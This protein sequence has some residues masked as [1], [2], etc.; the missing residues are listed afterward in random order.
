M[1]VSFAQIAEFTGAETLVAAPD[2][3]REIG[4]FCWDSREIEPG[5]FFIALAGEHHDGHDF[6]EAALETGAAG[7]LVSQMPSLELRASAHAHG[8]ALLHVADTQEALFALATA[9]RKTLGA[10]VI[11]VT[12]SSGKTGTKE[13]VAAVLRQYDP[14]LTASSGNHNNEVGLPATI[15]GANP[16]SKLLIL[17]MGMYDRGE[18][19][20]LCN[21]AAPR[22]GVVTN[23]GLAHLEVVGTRE[24]IARAKAELI[25]ALPNSSG[26][27]VLNGDD[28]WT[29]FIRE[30]SHTAERSVAVLQ[31]GM[32]AHNDIR[33]LNLTFREEDGRPIFDLKTLEADTVSVE[34]A[35]QGE[36]SVM[37]ALAAA[38]VG[39]HFGIPAP[40][41]ASA[42][43]SVQP[44]AMRQCN[45]LLKNGIRLIDDT[46]NANPDSMRAALEVLAHMPR[47][48][49]HVAVLG[50]MLELGEDEVA[51]H[52]EL[53]RVVAAT[54]VDEL[55]TI[56]ALARFIAEGAREAGL[57][58]R[59][60]R[61][62]DTIEE[63]NNAL[64]VT[65]TQTLEA[66]GAQ[67]DGHPIVLVKA[68]RSKGLERVVRHLTEVFGEQTG[69]PC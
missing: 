67:H 17:E 15:L 12:G 2:A 50:D 30:V 39:V 54:A 63:G 42:L 4:T 11:G 60:I 32:Q 20:A 45:I 35:L 58:E 6:L 69:S 36:H 61:S 14:E 68:S 26:L 3:T 57:D 55:I 29:P 64:V 13:L 23:I 62:F 27:A 24:N 40:R 41:I 1:Q 7:L 25:E 59:C 22:I 19:A 10:L 28:P 18:I 43:A 16:A 66:E 56:G 51:F 52:L 48:G 44:P 9:A 34:L 37:N 21:V 33:A 5:A 38:A 8:A 31:Y 49:A 46:Y 65:L 53:G 47:R